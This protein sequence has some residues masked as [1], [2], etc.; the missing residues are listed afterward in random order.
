[1]WAADASG[2]LGLWDFKHAV[3][4]VLTSSV[5]GVVIDA[6]AEGDRV[7]VLSIEL[8]GDSYRP[9]V[10]IFAN[11]K[12]EARL[13]LG[14]NI[15]LTSQPKLDLCLIAGRPWVVVGGRQWLQLFDWSTRRLLA[16]W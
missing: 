10:A 5:P 2:K 9:A 6:A 14:P 11:G 3:A 7:A 13:S 8:T 16:E 1:M 15:G 12:E 4:P